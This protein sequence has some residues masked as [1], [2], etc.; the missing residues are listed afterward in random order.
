MRVNS[1]ANKDDGCVAVSK[2]VKAASFQLTP[3]N[4]YEREKVF[5]CLRGDVRRTRPLDPFYSV[6]AS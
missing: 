4:A 6:S 5:F 1:V 3:H 2:A